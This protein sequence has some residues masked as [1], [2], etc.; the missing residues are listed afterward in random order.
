M[1]P[2]TRPMMLHNEMSGDSQ[3]PN[4]LIFVPSFGKFRSL[5][6]RKVTFIMRFLIAS[7]R[8]SILRRQNFWHDDIK[9]SK[10]GLYASF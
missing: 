7:Y 10:G 1:D 5:N 4:E 9:S 8:R 3:N 2:G 6:K